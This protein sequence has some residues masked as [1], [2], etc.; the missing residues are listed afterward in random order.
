MTT[1]TWNGTS[2]N[3]TDAASWSPSGVPTSGD[4]AI[5]NAGTVATTGTISGVTFQLNQANGATASS[6]L[7]LNNTTID[8]TSALVVN[9]GQTFSTATPAVVS[10]TGTSTLAGTGS[11]YGTQ[12]QFSIA[13]GATLVNSGAMNFYSS[14]PTTVGGGTLQNNGTIAFVNPNA[15]IQAPVLNDP[16]TGNGTIA[17]G[18]HARL[19]ISGTVGA[20]QTIVFNDGS[21]GNEVLQ[22]DAAAN[23]SAAINGFSV[24]DK[25]F[26]INVPYTSASYSGNSTSGTLTLL[27]GGAT[28]ARLNFV[29]NYTLSSFNIQND[30]LGGSSNELTIT[31]SANNNVSAGLPAGFQGGGGGSLPVYRFFDTI[32]G[33]HLFT[34][35]LS[36]AQQILATRPDLTE[37]TNNFGAVTQNNPSAVP[38]YRFFEQANGTHFYTSSQAEFQGLTTPGSGSYRSDLVYEATSTIFEDSAQ[39]AGDVAVYRLFDSIK[40][41]QFLTGSQT[42]YQGL[43]TA[44]SATYRADLR[45]EGIAFYAPNG[46]FK[47]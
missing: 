4:I 30:S 35:S 18:E 19:E 28:S 32:Y 39:Q 21:N 8:A 37:E 5:I 34:Q 7:A 33:T 47:A 45:P 13:A 26:L 46:T 3:F 9:N 10:V 43:T 20:G 40:G 17:L 14:S 31:T 27:N 36:E 15:T 41:T 38:V 22:F 12:T 44:G 25:L 23:V 16:I 24:S 42:E 6:T 11:F 1:R 29:G 2:G